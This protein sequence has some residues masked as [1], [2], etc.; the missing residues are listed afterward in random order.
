M[1]LEGND[2]NLQDNL[3]HNTPLHTAA[4]E[5]HKDV[6]EVLLAHGS[7]INLQTE[8]GDI[9]LH[10][11]AAEGHKDVVEVLLAHGSNVNSQN[12][13][14]DTPLYDAA[15]RGHKDVVEALLAHGSNVNLQ[16]ES[17]DIPL[18]GAAIRGHQGVVEVLLAH[19]SNVNSQDHSESTPLHGAAFR[20]HKD[21]VEVLL[22]H[23]SDIN[24]QNKFKRTPLSVALSSENTE[25]IELLIAHV[26]K[27]EHCGT[28]INS[29]GFLQNKELIDESQIFSAI[30][31]E[32]EQ[33]IRKLKNIHLSGSDL[34][35]FDIF[36]AQ[37]NI[38][39]LARYS[40]NDELANKI[41][42][43]CYIYAPLIDYSFKA[44]ANRDKLLQSAVA[45]INH[46][47]DAEETSASAPS[48]LSLPLELKLMILWYLSNAELS[49][50]QPIPE[51]EKD[52]VVGAS[53]IYDEE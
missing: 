10:G 41:K 27:L 21:V 2:V 32:C 25:I 18:H 1:I 35:V 43:E 29:S 12:Y 19:G 13:L 31:Q 52:Q 20:E 40:N 15:A 23:G 16:T 9:P 14:K 11:A 39:A 36:I 8:S 51:E 50:I 33:E 38:N 7:N 53:T 37:K 26:V 49:S 17:G 22:T 6:V 48:L 3:S 24:L 34:S 46:I 4:A 47:L 44:G 28:D 30:K 45:S 5:G 42:N